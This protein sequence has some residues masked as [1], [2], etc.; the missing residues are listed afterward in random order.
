M[1]TEFNS[2]EPDIGWTDFIGELWH[3]EK[4]F[5]VTMARS[6]QESDHASFEILNDLKYY[7]SEDDELFQPN[8]VP[9]PISPPTIPSVSTSEG[10]VQYTSKKPSHF[11]SVPFYNG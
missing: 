10:N 4:V 6:C 1:E 8:D 5:H 7:T 2:S 3:C 11:H 9:L